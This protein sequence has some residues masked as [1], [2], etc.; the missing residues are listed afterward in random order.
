MKAAWSLPGGGEGARVMRGCSEPA[1][2]RSATRL[3]RGTAARWAKGPGKAGKPRVL[4]GRKLTNSEPRPPIHS[5]PFP[6]L[7]RPHLLPA[8]GGDR[9]AL[10]S[11]S[12][13][14][15]V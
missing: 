3:H 10:A 8:S 2:P 15:P 12:S 14:R 1:P 9:W 4:A 5:F 7:P 6:A 11:C 13:P